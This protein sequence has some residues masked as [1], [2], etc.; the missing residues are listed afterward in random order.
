MAL[1][2]ALT[3]SFQIT[4]FWSLFNPKEYIMDIANPLY[5]GKLVRL[6]R[7]EERTLSTLAEWSQEFAHLGRWLLPGPD[8]A[9]SPAAGQK[10]S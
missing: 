7:I 8:P 1:K 3:A 2:V 5:T 6:T 9:L 4:R 10:S